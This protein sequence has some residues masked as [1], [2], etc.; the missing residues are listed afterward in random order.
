M[1]SI[2]L[3]NIGLGLMRPGARKVVVG[4]SVLIEAAMFLLPAQHGL[5]N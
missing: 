2:E 1:I 3:K 5:P 4:S